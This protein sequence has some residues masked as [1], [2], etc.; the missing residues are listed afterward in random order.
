MRVVHYLNQFFGGL[1]G[2]EVAN[3]PPEVRDGAVG[4]GRLLERVLGQDSQVV[5]TV[6]CGDNYAAENPE[7]L[8]DFV[9]KEVAGCKA[10]L[11]VSG[12]C[13]EAGRYGAAAGALCVAVS[14]EFSI[15]AVTGMALENPGVDLYRQNLYIVDSGE[16]VSGMEATLS[17]MA[18]IAA[19]LAA[20]QEMGAPAE[21]G[22]IPRGILHDG[23]VEKS[24]AE[25]MVE[26]LYA[27]TRGESFQTELTVTTFPSIPA[28][29]P[30]VDIS[31]ARVAIVTDGGL[32]HQGNPDN[33]AHTA[34]TT[35]GSYD[36]SKDD[37]LKG[38]DYEVA[39]RGYDTRYVRQDPDRL[40]PVD[41]MRDL[42]REG[43]VGKFHDQF[44]STS[45][46][47]NPL[48]NSRRL[49]QEIAQ[50]LKDSGVDA[51]ILTSA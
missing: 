18:A 34:A 23:F 49:G 19:K 36:I 2:E 29:P 47:A 38:E 8:K 33:I 27:K 43:V 10:E 42:E 26:M 51:V 50:K 4:P 25:R 41:V 3:S 24:A 37:D 35:W 40:V 11:F 21:D 7:V 20:G 5:K 44:I 15:P 32:V 48:A 1:G 28:P 13:F 39:H 45:G 16:S 14:A 22:Y 31:K 17:K 6:I 9:L 46:L 30:V 12:P